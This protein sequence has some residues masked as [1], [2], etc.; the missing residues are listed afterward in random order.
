MKTIKPQFYNKPIELLNRKIL[1]EFREY[2]GTYP[3]YNS[4]NDSAKMRL[5]WVISQYD[6]GTLVFKT[7]I[8]KMF[9]GFYKNIDMSKVKLEQ[10]LT[11]LEDKR[12]ALD[13]TIQV[14]KLDTATKD[15]KCP[16]KRLVKTYHSIIDLENENNK[17]IAIDD[18]KLA[19]GDNSNIVKLGMFCILEDT[20]SRK[21]FKR[22]LIQG[23]EMWILEQTGNIDSIIKSSEDFCNQQGKNLEDLN[24]DIIF[25]PHRCRYSEEMN[26]CMDTQL[27]SKYTEMNTLLSKIEEVTTLLTIYSEGAKNYMELLENLNKELKE[28]LLLVTKLKEKTDK[29]LTKA[30]EEVINTKEQSEFSELYTRIDNYLERIHKLPPAEM[31]PLL[32]TLVE[33]YGRIDNKNVYTKVG[34]KIIVCEHHTHFIK[35]YANPNR[36]KSILEY[37]KTKWCIETEGKYYCTNCGQEVFDG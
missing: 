29:Y 36:S 7:I 1:E 2:Y 10:E 23:S 32:N 21:L 6:Q 11:M 9:S 25:D 15:T 14:I 30:Y 12:L 27:V 5:S 37:L 18:D 22:S 28:T 24:N 3:Y 26:L 13:R 31:Y 17:D 16:D 19:V 8:L 34:N 35:Y 20:V 33:K 4:F